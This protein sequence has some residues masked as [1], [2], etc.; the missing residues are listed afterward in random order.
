MP[1]IA[2]L[3]LVYRS[4]SQTKH[5]MICF[6]LSSPRLQI[7]TSFCCSFFCLAGLNFSPKKNQGRARSE[8]PLLTFQFLSR[9]LSRY[10]GNSPTFSLSPWAGK[11][12]CLIPQ[13]S[14]PKTGPAPG[15]DLQ[16]VLAALFAQVIHGVNI[17]GIGF[18]G[19]GPQH[20]TGCHGGFESHIPHCLTGSSNFRWFTAGRWV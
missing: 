4:L 1:S 3:I 2:I 14:S 9:R 15:P 6:C 20:A 16:A 11:A 12:P 5:S 13:N 7:L 17:F 18:N 19:P 10:T 8:D